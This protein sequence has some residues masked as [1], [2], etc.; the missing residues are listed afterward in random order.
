MLRKC[1]P[2]LSQRSESGACPDSPTRFNG[3]RRRGACDPSMDRPSRVLL[4]TLLVRNV[5][6]LHSAKKEAA[7]LAA[8]RPAFAH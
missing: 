8:S 2:A 4:N 3:L 6:V 1:F 5:E 7:N